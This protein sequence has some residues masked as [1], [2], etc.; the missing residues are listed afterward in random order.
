MAP[1]RKRPDHHVTPEKA[2]ILSVLKDHIARHRRALAMLEQ[3]QPA[4]DDWVAR[5][6][7]C[8][9][10]GG[11]LFWAGNGGSAAD[12]QHL[13][14][15]LVGRYRLERRGQ[16]SVALTTDTSVLTAL[17]NDYGFEALFARQVEALC[18]P[19]DLLILLSTS[20]NSPN[21]LRAAEQARAQNCPTFALLGKDGGA[22][23]DRVDASLCIGVAETAAIQEMHITAGHYFCH[24]LEQAMAAH[25]RGDS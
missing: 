1:G 23:R 21:L 17:G 5:G 19:D 11:T 15:E 14:A 4:L 7:A 24:M 25:S 12:A 16:A 3:Q 2:L 20:G 10:R 6:L 8:M 18:G 9:E 13:A 22:L